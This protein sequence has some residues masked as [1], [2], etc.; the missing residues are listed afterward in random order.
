MLF[1]YRTVTTMGAHELYQRLLEYGADEAGIQERFIGDEELYQLCIEKFRADERFSILENAL[2]AKNCEAAFEAAHFLKGTSGNLGLTPFYEAVCALVEVL[3]EK[4]IA[5][6]VEEYEKVKSAEKLLF[7]Y[8][9]KK[10]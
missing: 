1:N 10:D 9:D 4:D 3:R 6:A 5:R 7:G 2:A 8:I